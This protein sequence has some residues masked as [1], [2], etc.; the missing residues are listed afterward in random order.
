MS[1]AGSRIN[2][3]KKPRFPRTKRIVKRF[4]C[5]TPV[6]ILLG[7]L[8]RDKIPYCGIR[9]YTRSSAVP[10]KNKAAMVF[11]VYESAE[12]RFIQKY[13]N[14][15]LRTIELGS[16]LGGVTSHIARRM[17]TDRQLLCIEANP[18]MLFCLRQNLIQ[19]ASHLRTT[20]VHGAIHYGADVAMFN[21]ADNPLDSG[22]CSLGAENSISVPAFRLSV[23]VD[24]LG[25]D[26]YQLISDIEGAELEIVQHDGAAL[27]RC[28]LAIVEFHDHDVHGAESCSSA[29]E[30]RWLKQDFRLIDKFGPV[31]VM[32]R[33]A[34]GV[35]SQ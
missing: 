22:V 25:E 2:V 14:P 5:S 13:L 15:Q 4:L 28:M 9:I 7:T 27:T 19:N 35:P 6:G 3:I 33:V 18:K 26:S 10:Y 30:A 16:S 21:V 24:Q 17:N 34:S 20:L 12:R 29:A 32:E 11:G 31:C 1:S 23:L 8:F